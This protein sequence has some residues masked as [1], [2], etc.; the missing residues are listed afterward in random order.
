GIIYAG[1]VDPT[2]LIK[3]THGVNLNFPPVRKFLE[4]HIPNVFK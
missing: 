1:T 3:E 2:A 4:Q